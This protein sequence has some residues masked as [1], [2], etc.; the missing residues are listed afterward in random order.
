MRF[1]KLVLLTTCGVLSTT[2]E[3]HQELAELLSEPNPSVAAL[4]HLNAKFTK[5]NAHASKTKPLGSLL[6]KLA[7]DAA[8]K[9]I[10]KTCHIEPKAWANIATVVSNSP[11]PDPSDLHLALAQISL[12]VATDVLASELHVIPDQLTQTAYAKTLLAQAALS[13]ATSVAA[14]KLQM[15]AEQADKLQLVSAAIVEDPDSAKALLVNVATRAAAKKLNMTPEQIAQLTQ[16][17]EAMAQDPDSAKALMEQAALDLATSAAADKLHM[18]SEQTEQA[19]LVANALLQDTANSQILLEHVALSVAT[20]A[21][22]DKL[23]LS[24]DQAVQIV[25]LGDALIANPHDAPNLLHDAVVSTGGDMLAD[26]LHGST[27]KVEQAVAAANGGTVSPKA[28]RDIVKQ[29]ALNA[30]G[31]VL[32]SQLEESK[33]SDTIRDTGDN[34]G[35]YTPVDFGVELTNSEKSKMNLASTESYAIHFLGETVPVLEEILRLLGTRGD[36]LDPECAAL[37]A[38]LAVQAAHHMFSHESETTASQWRDALIQMSQL[39]AEFAGDASEFA[40]FNSQLVEAFTTLL[41]VANMAAESGIDVVCIGTSKLELQTQLVMASVGTGFSCMARCFRGFGCCGS[42]AADAVVDPLDSNN[43]LIEANLF[44][45]SAVATIRDIV[46]EVR[47]IKTKGPGGHERLEILKYRISLQIIAL[48]KQAV[49]NDSLST[50]ADILKSKCQL[51]MGL[52]TGVDGNG[53]D[54]VRENVAKNLLVIATKLIASKPQLVV[55]AL[56]TLAT[57]PNGAV[58]ALKSSGAKA[59]KSTGKA[60]AIANK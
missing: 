39:V 16:I 58:A 30:A 60:M 32:L 12:G 49:S 59:V 6:G 41:N 29:T 9:Q 17:T 4:S 38:N 27:E 44:I 56:T 20:R 34:K 31:G 54:K 53:F 28:T 33:E 57:N 3:H 37:I 23:H 11:S 47:A 15:T 51:I 7:A 43:H 48:V 2:D 42:S 10:S 45:D 18:T 35:V 8:T 24:S 46:A 19:R 14:D 13:L 21:A 1:A 55:G 50:V 52:L 25:Q 26:H 22:A 5:A 36:S 40:S